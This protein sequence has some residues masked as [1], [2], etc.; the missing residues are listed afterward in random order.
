MEKFKNYLLVGMA[1]AIMFLLILKGC[2]KPNTPSKPNFI[3]G[4]EIVKYDTVTRPYKVV[5]FKTKYYPKWDTAYVDTTLRDKP[6]GKDYLV[7]EYSDSIP[8]GT[9][10]IFTRF[11]VVGILKEQNISY[12][13]KTPLEVIKTVSRVDTLNTVTTP[14]WS[15]YGG[16]ET[17]GNLNQFNIS[18]YVTLNVR[19]A[20]ISY[21]YG[22]LDKSHNIGVGIR[23]FKSKK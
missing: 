22:L 16:L 23:I 20:S 6:F 4:E 12:R 11:K 21:R 9:L 5:E 13:L 7:R 14:K 10:T 18:P 17:G 1:G 8:D 2:E 3:K 19:K 15:L